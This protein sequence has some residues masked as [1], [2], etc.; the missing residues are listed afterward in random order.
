MSTR[1][2]QSD[3][4][5]RRGY[6]I[7]MSDP[8]QTSLAGLN[9]AN[10]VVLAAG[11]CGYVDEMSDVLDLSKV[12]AVVTKS[13]TAESREGNLPWRILDAPGGMLN[14]IGL[15]NVGL[16]AFMTD[17]MP[18][19]TKCPTTVIG[20]IAGH[21]TDD[22]VQVAETF[23]TADDLPAVELNVSCPNTADGLQFGESP[24]SLLALLKD[25]RPVLTKTKMIVKLSPNAPSIVDMAE[26]AVEGGADVISMINTF[27]A[28]SIDVE[29]RKPRIAN[30][31]AGFSGPAIHPI[32]VRMIHDVYRSV[33]RDANVPILG[34]GGVYR[35]QDAAE[36]I[37]AGA[38]AVGM[39]T[40]LFVDPRSPLRVIKGLRKWTERQRAD[41][42]ADLVGCV[43]L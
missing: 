17:K 24:S 6:T 27:T 38:T 41:N 9:L 22:Y 4:S 3:T 2:T 32:A 30:G 26:A 39:G 35:W 29:T 15:A 34:Y 37:L 14:A 43:K 25:V 21:S 12:G 20:S 13:I 42:V 19:A 31:T 8:L 7:A 5:P 40:A 36:M 23:D 18:R 33:A 16:E 1:W 28:L 11:T 10:P